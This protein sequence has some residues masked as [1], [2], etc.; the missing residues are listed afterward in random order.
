VLIV[1]LFHSAYNSA[2]SLGEQKFTGELISGSALLYA[3]VALVAL[4]MLVVFFTRGC[5]AYKSPERRLQMSHSVDVAL[6]HET[7]GIVAFYPIA[8][9]SAWA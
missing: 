5:L 7:R 4:T 2:T 1:A 8:S 9:G 6:G 3:V